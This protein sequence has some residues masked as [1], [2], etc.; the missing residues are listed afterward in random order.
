M[1]EEGLKAAF[2]RVKE[3]MFF[4]T[5]EISE[6]KNLIKSL[7]NEIFNLKFSSNE[8]LN[9]STIQHIN[10]TDNQQ[11]SNTSTLP[12]EI[13]GLKDQNMLT[14]T[15]NRGVSTNSQTIQQLDQH[16]QNMPISLNSSSFVSENISNNLEKATQMINS[17]EDIKK[18]IKQKFDSLTPQEAL[19][20]A[21]IYQ[22]DEEKAVK[23]DYALL[24]EKLNLTQS[25]IRDY[26]QRMITKGIPVVKEKIHNKRVILSVSPQFKKIAPLSTILMLKKL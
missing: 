7:Q 19:V 16:I 11:D 12:Q 21:W 6:M 10:P 13:G 1:N 25:S 23:V 17:L 24:A 4:L 2:A 20:F 26:V 8:I 22:L 3:D 15:G 9:N 14:S 5:Q 18:T